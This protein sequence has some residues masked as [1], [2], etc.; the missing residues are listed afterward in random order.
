M[1]EHIF[2]WKDLSN[3]QFYWFLSISVKPYLFINRIFIKQSFL[4]N[5]Y[6]IELIIFL[7]LFWF[8][9]YI[10]GFVNEKNGKEKKENMN[11]PAQPTNSC[12][13]AHFS[14]PALADRWGPPIRPFIALHRRRHPVYCAI[15]FVAVSASL[16]MHCKPPTL[17]PALA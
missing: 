4:Q 16:P 9:E 12:T 10:Y 6:F 14:Y 5:K 13:G 8:L 11:R 3:S 2:D 17:A 7:D 15:G 1:L